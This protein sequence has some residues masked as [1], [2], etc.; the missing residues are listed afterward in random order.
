MLSSAGVPRAVKDLAPRRDKIRPGPERKPIADRARRA[1]P[2]A[3]T[4]GIDPRDPKRAIAA[5]AGT[6]R[7]TAMTRKLEKSEWDAFF[8]GVSKN[9]S[10]VAAQ[11]E[12]ASLKLGD[13]IEANW[14]PLFGVV[15]DAKDD[16]VEIAMEGLDHLIGT[17]R[18]IFVDE[19]AGKLVSF[20]I[21]DGDDVHQIIKLKPPIAAP[22]RPS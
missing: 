2:E 8:S 14:L 11:V 1:G 10:G 18:D 21:I 13:Q 5:E 12:V 16:I 9:L 22:S 15:Y 7:E 3:K 4:I 19:D 6:Q 17:P 20:E